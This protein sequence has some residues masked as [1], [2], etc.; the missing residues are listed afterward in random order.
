MKIYVSNLSFQAVDND[1]RKLFSAFGVVSA[2]N[3]V[4][5]N[6]TRRSRGF[7]FIDMEDRNAGETA[8][9]SLHNSTFMQKTIQVRE[10]S[11]SK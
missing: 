4:M 7:A 10:A 9:A 8:V 3:V 1:L 6:Y 2:A 5:D 11:V